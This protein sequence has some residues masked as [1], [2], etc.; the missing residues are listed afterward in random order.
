MVGE[1]NVSHILKCSPRA[2]DKVQWVQA[3]QRCSRKSLRRCQSMDTKVLVSF[4]KPLTLCSFFIVHRLYAS[5]FVFLTFCPFQ[6]IRRTIHEEDAKVMPESSRELREGP[7]ERN[8]YPDRP[9]TE[10]KIRS[11]VSSCAP[12][13]SLLF[14]ERPGISIAKAFI[15]VLPRPQSFVN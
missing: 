10:C 11:L 1:V 12:P 5:R 2:Y 15:L 8:L 13:G 3:G 9:C 14:K 7:H 4:R 6:P